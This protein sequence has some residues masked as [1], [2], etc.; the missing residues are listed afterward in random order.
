MLTYYISANVDS[1]RDDVGLLLSDIPVPARVREYAATS[2]ELKTRDEIFSAMVVYGFLNYENGFVSIPNEELKDKFAEMAEKEPSLGTV[3]NTRKSGRMLAATKAG[4][5]KTMTEILSF[6]HNTE[7]PLLVYNN[8]AELA[9]IIKLAYLQ[10]R[11]LYHIER[12]DKAGT[13]YVDF[14]FYP[15]QKDDDGIIIKLKVNHTTEEAVKQIRD[16]QYTLKFQ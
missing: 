12:E 10:A 4:D 13:G 15:V 16:R 1:V 11:D 2:M 3:Y 14:I 7:S 6:V 8:E 9:S 5:T